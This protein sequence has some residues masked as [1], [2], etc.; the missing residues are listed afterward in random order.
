MVTHSLNLVQTMCD[1]AAWLDHGRLRAVGAALDVV[2]QY[3]DEVNVVEAE[4]MGVATTDAVEVEVRSAHDLISIDE[5]ERPAG[6]PTGGGDREPPR[7]ACTGPRGADRGP[8]SFA[9]ESEAG[10]YVANPGMRT[11]DEPGKLPVGSGYVDYRIDELALGPGQYTF[12]VAAHDHSGT[13]VL[14]KRERFLTLRVQPGPRLVVFGL[15]DMLGRW[16][17]PVT[18]AQATDDRALGH[19]QLERPGAPATPSRG[20]P[21]PGRRP[22]VLRL[23]R[24]VARDGVRYGDHLRRVERARE[25][26]PAEPEYRHWLREHRPPIGSL[27]HQTEPAT[28]ERIRTRVEFVVLPGGGGDVALTL[29]SLVAQTFRGWRATVVGRAPCRTTCGWR[30]LA[31][32]PVPCW[33]GW[34]PR[35]SRTTWWSCWRPATASSRTWCSTS[36]PGPGTTRSSPCSTGTTT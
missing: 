10:V 5:V 3:L 29:D 8:L 30:T 6:T 14:D 22:A 18:A 4:R 31:A 25:L 23:A 28:A 27:I 33:P 19:R 20:S 1:N 2:H 21:R 15:V 32:T 35:A 7:S 11:G 36:R 9:V 17:L 26:E 16:E 24:Q 12:S 13:T 34:R